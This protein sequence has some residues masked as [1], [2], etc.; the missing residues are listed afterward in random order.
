MIKYLQ[1][2]AFLFSSIL[3]SQ[4][5]NIIIPYR[6]GNVW[7]FCDTLGKVVV[8][9][10]FDN[11]INVRYDIYNVRK[12]SFLIQKNTKQFVVNEK[13]QIT[14][15]INHAYDSLRLKEFDIDNIE[16][17][18][19]GKM[20]LYSNLKE[21]IPCN[22]KRIDVVGNKSY[23]VFLG[24]KCGIVNSKSKLIVPIK[25]DII[26]PSWGDSNKSNSKFVW[27]ATLGKVNTIFYDAKIK[28]SDD[29]IVGVLMDKTSGNSSEEETSIIT[30]LLKNYDKVIRD[31]YRNI[32]YVTKN[33]KIGVFSMLY[34]KLIIDTDYEE[35]NFAD[36]NKGKL[37]FKVK[38]NGK[39]GFVSENNIVLLPIE[40]DKIQYN[41]KINQFE[42][43]KNN[44][45]GVK[46]FNTIYPTIEAKYI[47]ILDY[48]RLLI[49]NNWSFVIFLVKTEKGIGFIG[50]NGV[51]YFK[52]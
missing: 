27:E 19:D 37:V 45:V 41:S 8:K 25:Y 52:N 49:N 11:V 32:A 47:E 43:L 44:R 4:T 30:D 17:F 5:D 38:V 10:Y 21:I 18:K 1:I 26:Y 24:D 15:P 31:D 3:Y 36:N 20:G 6:D 35:V 34:K 22:Y 28:T 39:F 29:D 14:I 33:N 46:V 51:E 48:K 23:R 16:V 7:G 40:Y 42:I 2:F 13:N 50:E 9:P 12:A